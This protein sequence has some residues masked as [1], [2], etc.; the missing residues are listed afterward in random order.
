MKNKKNIIFLFSFSFIFLISISSF[1]PYVKSTDY[2]TYISAT[3]IIK[4]FKFTTFDGEEI[5]DGGVYNNKLRFDTQASWVLYKNDVTT[6]YTIEDGG[7]TSLKYRVVLRNKINIYTN[8]RINQMAQNLIEV[9][10]DY[11][12]MHYIH[13]NI[14]DIVE[15]EWWEYITWEY[16]DFGD[17]YNWNWQNNYFSGRLT[18]SFDID[19]N[20]IPDVFGDYA[21]KNFDYIA[22]SDAGIV[23]SNY[24][25]MSTDMPD[26]V[27][28]S[29]SEEGKEGREPAEWNLGTLQHSD[30]DYA[31]QIYPNIN[32]NVNSEPIQSFD[33]GILPDT[34]GSS[35][36]PTTKE[37]TPIWDPENEVSMTGGLIHYDVNSLSPVV[38]KYEGTLT[39]NEYFLW[40][41]H[42]YTPNAWDWWAEYVKEKAFYYNTRVEYNDVALHGINRY[43]QV[44]MYIAFDIWASVNIGTLTEYYEQMRLQAPEEYYDAL[45][46]STLAG[47]WTGS[48]IREGGNP[49][50]TIWK[51]WEQAIKG[52]LGG[53]FGGAGGFIILIII[54]AIFI[55]GLFIF[56]K[57]GIPMIRG[58]QRRKENRIG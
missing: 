37:G 27:I 30:N 14:F 3:D 53:I 1:T 55:A 16:W 18:M 29:P 28:L 2:T 9:K 12:G 22:V 44:D 45:I 47:G 32:L 39:Y 26:I 11:L 57:I 5:V 34:T 42:E 20:P 6:L 17:I 49:I 4:N 52:F 19:D 41:D 24:G 50:D 54:G 38:Y 58:R 15:A 35:M 8:V 56:M 33:S 25:L 46:W 10:K 51:S 23:T 48:E 36:D 31:V 7:N 21:D 40:T 13:R 43:I